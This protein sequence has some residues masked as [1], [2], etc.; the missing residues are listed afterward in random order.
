MLWN[1]IFITRIVQMNLSLS[2]NITI[3]RG[4]NFLRARREI[5]KHLKMEI[6]KL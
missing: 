4:I 2:L 1:Y 5:C 3:L 6:G